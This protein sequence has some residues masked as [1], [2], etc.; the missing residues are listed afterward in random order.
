MGEFVRRYKRHEIRDRE[1]IEEYNRVRT[2]VFPDTP[3]SAPQDTVSLQVQVCDFV[4][5]DVVVN[6][7]SQF[8]QSTFDV[9]CAQSLDISQEVVNLSTSDIMQKLNSDGDA[10]AAVAH[11]LGGGG[12]QEIRQKIE[13]QIKTALNITL[14]SE[15]GA[16]LNLS[17]YINV[18]NSNSTYS[19]GL[20]QELKVSSVAT[21]LGTTGFANEVFN[22]FDFSQFGEVLND[23]NTVQAGLDAAARIAKAFNDALRGTTVA[24]G[25]IFG[26]LMVIGILLAAAAV[27]F[28]VPAGKDKKEL[29]TLMATLKCKAGN[30]IKP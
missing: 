9:T 7:A 22:T 11:A 23:E 24:L 20:S 18:V 4:C 29:K 27:G 14:L 12:S 3:E 5:S 6:N 30:Q 2:L 28:G 17:Q 1:F 19:A 13:V 16:S 10:F 26:I 8:A 15:M 25:T 21:F